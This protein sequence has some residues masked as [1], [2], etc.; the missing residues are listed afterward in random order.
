MYLKHWSPIIA[1]LVMFS[2]IGAAPLDAPKLAAPQ[3]FAPGIVSGPANDGSPTFDPKGTTLF[4]TRSTATWGVILESHR[5]NAAH[6][7][8]PQIAPFSGKWNDSS[9]EFAPN[10]LYVV[11]VSVRSHRANLYRS[12][13]AGAGWGEPVRLPDAVNI[14]P[15]IWKP[16]IVADGSIYF[17]SIDKEGSKR[18]FYSH[19]KSG[20]FETAQPVSFLVM[21]PPEMSILRWRLTSR[22][23]F[24]VAMGELRGI[25][26]ISCLSPSKRLVR[27]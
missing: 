19:Y 20:N 16:S 27:G 1:G 7:S 8:Q 12:N 5:T 6:W 18:L 3:I 24:S 26:K 2:L 21:E 23:W 10:G 17:V 22:S 15:S 4:F 25:Q 11:Y 13:R 14:G 9:P